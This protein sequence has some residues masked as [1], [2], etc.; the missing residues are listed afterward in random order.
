MK[1][2][3]EKIDLW[4]KENFF[5]IVVFNLVIIVLYL[6]R[7]AGYFDPYFLISVNFIVIFGLVLTIFL[8]RAGSRLMFLTALLF[9]LFAGFLRILNLDTWAERTA[10]YCFESLIIGFVLLVFRR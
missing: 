9:W 4:A 5:N 2:Y 10:I 1:K 7:S 3:K 6:L 8:F